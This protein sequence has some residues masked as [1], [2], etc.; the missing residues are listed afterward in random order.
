MS[1]R[2]MIMLLGFFIIILPFLGFDS[3]VKTTISIIIG[4]LCIFIAYNIKSNIVQEVNVQ[5]VNDN[6]SK[7]FPY[8]ESITENS[9]NG[10]E[11]K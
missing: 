6:K 11:G 9:K 7:D 1:K 5:G 2:Q 8:V 4:L 10:N 3:F